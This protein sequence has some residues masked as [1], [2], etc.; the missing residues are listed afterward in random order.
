MPS[1]KLIYFNGR[2]RAEPIRYIFAQAGENYEDV[3]ISGEEFGKMKPTLP[4]GSLPVLEEDGKQLSGSSDIAR[5]LGEK[6][7]L[8]GANAWDNAQLGSIV[9]VINDLYACIIPVFFGKDDQ[10]KAEAK[11]KLVE[12]S[13][14]KYFGILEKRFQANKCSWIYGDKLTYVDMKISLVVD[15]LSALDATVATTYPGLKT[16][17]EKVREQPG[18]AEWI[19]KRPES[20]F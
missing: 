8:A 2:G 1:Y 11:K 13:I 10:S 3:R 6:F 17:A 18:I 16:L 14:P 15:D 5:Y 12:E 20:A 9:D 7:S 4:T 19:K